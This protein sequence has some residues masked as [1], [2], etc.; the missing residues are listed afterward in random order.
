MIIILLVYSYSLIFGLYFYVMHANLVISYY[1][2][3]VLH[4]QRI[5]DAQLTYQLGLYIVTAIR[6]IQRNRPPWQSISSRM[7]AQQAHDDSV[8]IPIEGDGMY[9]GECIL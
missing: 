9:M 4:L 1:R 6:F 2:C 5:Y 8:V 7:N 3:L